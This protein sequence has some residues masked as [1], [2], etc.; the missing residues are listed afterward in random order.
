MTTAMSLRR[1]AL[2][3]TTVAPILIGAAACAVAYMYDLRQANSLFDAQLRELALYAS[4]G[5][6]DDTPADASNADAFVLRVWSADGVIRRATPDAVELPRPERPGFATIEIQGQR[7]RVYSAIDAR[8]S[9]TVAQ[10]MAVRDEIGRNAG[11]EAAVPVLL[12]TLLTWVAALSMLGSLGK[13][14]RGLTDAISKRSFDSRD[15]VPLG[16]APAEVAPLVEGMNALTVRLQE[17]IDRQRRFVADAAHALRTPLTALQ[18][19][20]DNLA[21]DAN[22]PKGAAVREFSTGISRARALTEQLLRLAR[23]ESEVDPD[24]WEEVEISAIVKDCV[25]ELV[26]LADTRGVDLGLVCEEPVVIRG[27]RAELA[28]LFGNLIDNAVRYTPRGGAVDVGIRLD[29][30]RLA[31]DVV[32]TGGGVAEADIPR[33][34]DRFFRA[35]PAGTEGSGLGLSIA[36]A[37]AIRHGLSIELNNRPDAQGFAVRVAESARERALIRS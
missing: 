2:L 29:R 21:S 32:D 18:I 14:L 19:Q 1:R 9:A 27:I 37:V 3:W 16:D 8:R 35:A 33:L 22:A 26:P 6:D 20:L 17:A 25:A 7:W 30:G 11:I 10:R 28:L 24:G 15:P 23:S 13:Q 12:V 4:S 34:F 5:S 36:E 31:V